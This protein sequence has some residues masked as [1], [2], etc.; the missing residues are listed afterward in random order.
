M[1]L[2]DKQP[3]KTS[4]K[5]LDSSLHDRLVSGLDEAM[6]SVNPF[7]EKKPPEQSPRGNSTTAPRDRL[8]GERQSTMF[9]L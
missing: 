2:Q 8:H 5:P 9:T 1:S 6:L 3:P 7:S 4:D